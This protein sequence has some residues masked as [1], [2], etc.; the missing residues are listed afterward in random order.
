MS[1]RTCSECGNV[2][3]V[4]SYGGFCAQCLFRLGLESESE[5]P[6]ASTSGESEAIEALLPGVKGQH[7]AD[8]ELLEQIARGGMGVVFK[9]RQLSLNPVVLLKLINPGTLIHP[10]L[11]Q[12]F[13]T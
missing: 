4:E 11:I 2:I 13:K 7:L 1:S 6:S 12:R 10:E 3:L 8:Y 9:P 5:D